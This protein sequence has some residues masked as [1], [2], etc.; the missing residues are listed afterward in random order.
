MTE[1][2]P[3]YYDD[4]YQ[5]SCE[6]TVAEVLPDGLILDQTVFYPRGGGQS[7]DTGRIGSIDVVDTTR[8]DGAIVHHVGSMPA[9]AIGESVEAAVDWPRRY[10][11]MRNH[12]LLHIV[13]LVFK[14]VYG[15][16]RIRGSEVRPEK[17]RVDFEFFGPVANEEIEQRV[18]EIIDADLPVATQP[19]ESAP[20]KRVWSMPGFESIPCGGTHIRSTGEI[21]AFEVKAKR[22]GKQGV[23]V[24]AEATG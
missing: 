18:R 16:A 24:Y 14:E 9:I 5:R 4:N 2:R 1:T 17:A 10:A 23:R 19:D 13:Y 22:K 21:G 7:G 15:D 11:L 6:A 8:R 20:D 12:T 3:I